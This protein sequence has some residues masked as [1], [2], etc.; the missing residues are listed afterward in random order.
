MSRSDNFDIAESIRRISST[1]SYL[2]DLCAA[3]DGATSMLLSSTE[4]QC[5]DALECVATVTCHVVEEFFKQNPAS[6]KR[7]MQDAGISLANLG[8]GQKNKKDTSTVS[9]KVSGVRHESFLKVKDA[10]LSL[11]CR[12][13]DNALLV[14]EQFPSLQEQVA[15]LCELW[16]SSG[17]QGKER[18]VAQCLPYV[19]VK[20]LTTMKPVDVI[21]K[22]F[23]PIVPIL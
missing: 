10:F 19:A 17:V 8:G 3:L 1:K 15:K 6:C 13:H 22:A 4:D 23:F 14:K 2:M 18:L 7:S 9:T 11:S 5:N 20:A 21:R 16:W 12:L